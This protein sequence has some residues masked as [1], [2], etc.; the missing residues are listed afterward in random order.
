MAESILR[1][2]KLSVGYGKKVIVNG[3]EL[4]AER[5]KILTLIGPNGAGKSTILKTLCRELEPLGGA[6]YIGKEQINNLSGN[7]L[8]RSVSVLLTNRVKTE[9]MRCIDVVEMGRYPYTGNLGI[10][11]DDDHAK[12]NDA[13]K[14]VDIAELAYRDFDRISDGQRQRVLLAGAICRE[15]DVLILDEPTTFLD[16]K[17]KLELMSILKKLA[18]ER[19]TAIIISLHEL[20]LAQRV[21]DNII[22]VKGD[23]PDRVGAPEEIFS[24]DYI[25][26]LY[27]VPDGCFCE[28]FGT[29][30]LERCKG[31]VEVFVIGGGGNGISVYRS[32]RRRGIPFAAGIIHEND[33]EYPVAASLASELITERAFHV[34][35]Q[36]SFEKALVLMKKCG[37]VICAADKFGEMN[38]KCLMLCEEA[39]KLGI[40]AKEI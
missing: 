8:A 22:C 12:V 26:R 5:G 4:T 30:E 15:P 40:L 25:S 28:S 33:I 34:V 2:E 1:A 38:E 3:V 16:I 37:R 19:G 31:E 6:V 35:S 39:Q 20:D 13:M 10:L 11:S 32:L 27:G 24:G 21:S 9:Y 23:C 14:L 36:E 29:P 17:Y 18:S 7:A